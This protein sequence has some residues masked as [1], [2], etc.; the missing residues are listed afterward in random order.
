MEEL[1]LPSKIEV[2]P[3]EVN[4]NRATFKVEPCHFGYA[5]TLGNALRRV[6]LSSLPGAS[7]VAV[8]IDG[9]PHEFS[10]LSGVKE[11]VLELILNLKGLRLRLWS[12]ETV[13]L[14]LSVKGQREVTA[15]DIETSSD[16]EVM[17]PDL[18]IATLTAKD[19]KLEMEIFVGR[20]RGYV[21]VEERGEERSEIGLIAVDAMYSPVK[22][23]G[24]RREDTRVGKITN[25]DRL[26]MEVETDGTVTPEE[27]IDQSVRILLDHFTLLLNRGAVPEESAEGGDVLPE[28]AAEEGGQEAPVEADEE[29]E[30]AKPAV[31]GGKAKSAKA[32]KKK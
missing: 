12:E 11:D 26:V 2:I 10:A 29:D 5:M 23:V 4:P 25:Y 27:A 8:K 14:K 1:L 28:E 13:R 18:H 24:Y 7:V 17:N 21:P 31:K 16:V 15:G 30:K 32:S 6:L 3:D 20:G 9:A 22:E 19:S